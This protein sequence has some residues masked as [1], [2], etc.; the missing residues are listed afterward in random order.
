[1]RV[2]LNYYYL[3][4]GE[5]EL[6]CCQMTCIRSHGKLVLRLRTGSYM[7]LFGGV[8]GLWK[9]SEFLCEL[10]FF[11]PE[12]VHMHSFLQSDISGDS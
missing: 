8:G 1:M 10:C 2:E 3:R 7:V 4:G 5:T 11:S 6:Q 12:C 9:V